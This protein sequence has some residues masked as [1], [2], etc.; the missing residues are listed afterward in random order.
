M[1][2]RLRNGRNDGLGRW[3]QLP[4]Y[5]LE[6]A[7]WK[8]LDATARCIYIELKYRYN[9]SNNGRIPYGVREVAMALHIGKSTAARGFA[10]LKDRGFIIAGLEGKFERK[11]RHASEWLL[12]DTHRTSR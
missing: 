3:V 1:S 9:G 6:T 12:T 2:K 11:R 8:S 10:M 5:L 7:A 4:Y